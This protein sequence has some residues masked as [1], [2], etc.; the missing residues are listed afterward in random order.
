MFKSI[1]V[2][3]IALIVGIIFGAFAQIIFSPLAVIIRKYKFLK[4]PYALL[5]GI[6]EGFLILAIGI[7]IFNLFHVQATSL[8]FY[9]YAILITINGIKRLFADHTDKILEWGWYIGDF[10]GLLIG[11]HYLI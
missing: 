10:M 1:L 8:L 4:F 3:F 9:L 5:V 7:L 6:I 2:Y 11:T